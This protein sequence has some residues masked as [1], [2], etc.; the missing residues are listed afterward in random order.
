MSHK[1]QDCALEIEYIHCYYSTGIC[2]PVL[3][4]PLLHVISQKMFTLDVFDS[5]QNCQEGEECEDKPTRKVV[6]VLI[7]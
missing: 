7:R 4:C 3:E 6:K 1:F 2:A 5:Y